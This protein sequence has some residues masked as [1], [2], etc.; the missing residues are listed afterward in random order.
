MNRTARNHKS[1][2]ILTVGLRWMART[3]GAAS[4]L[5]LLAFA[6][7]GQEHL[8]LTMVEALVFLLFPVGVIVGFVIAWWRECSRELPRA[9]ES[10]V[11]S[12]ILLPLH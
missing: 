8:R 6:F 7:G 11:F 9:T 5:L 4:G 10:L 12:L 3:W 1:R 2:L